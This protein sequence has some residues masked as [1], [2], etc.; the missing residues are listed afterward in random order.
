MSFEEYPNN[1]QPDLTPEDA[2][3]QPQAPSGG[4]SPENPVFTRPVQPI[5]PDEPGRGWSEPVYE[6]YAPSNQDAYTPGR[7][8]YGAQNVPSPE[9][10][11]GKKKKKNKERRSHGFLKAVALVVVCAL[12]AGLSSWLVVDYMMDNRVTGGNKQ[13]FHSRHVAPA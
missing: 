7:Y 13:V 11:G 6:Q 2:G 12:V 10:M 4:D 3:A 5:V 1:E 8:A 9:D